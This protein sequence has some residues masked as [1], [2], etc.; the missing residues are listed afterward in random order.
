[1][2]AG[3]MIV[4]SLLES[5]RGPIV[6]VGHSYG[7]VVMTNAALGKD[8]TE[9]LV[10]VEACTPD[11]GENSGELSARFPGSTLGDRLATVPLPDGSMLESRHDLRYRKDHRRRLPSVPAAD[12]SAAPSG[13]VGR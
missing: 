9:A 11:E 4:A 1:M 13:P 3:V 8:N 6:R 12:R 7:G 5:I 2:L 10:F